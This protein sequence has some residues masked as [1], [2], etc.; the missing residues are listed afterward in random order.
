MSTWGPAPYKESVLYTPFEQ[1]LASKEEYLGQNVHLVLALFV[2]G[3]GLL[4]TFCER[5]GA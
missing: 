2:F 5:S 1:N 3:P 4:R